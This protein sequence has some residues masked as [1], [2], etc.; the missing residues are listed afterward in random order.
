M[1]TLSRNITRRACHRLRAARSRHFSLW[2]LFRRSSLDAVPPPGLL[3]TQDNLFHPFSRSPIPAIVERGKTVRELAPCPVCST[4]H[5]HTIAT[6]SET[7]Q[8]VEPPK[9]IAFECPDCGWP[10]HCS[11]EH[12]KADEEHKEYCARLR[13]VNEDEHD[14]R[15]GR[16]FPEF[17]LPGISV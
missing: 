5:S 16:T 3:L 2:N 1:S 8:T 9:S 13:E 12:W 17:G 7:V 4:H 15:S 11:E 10:T 14:L 6:T